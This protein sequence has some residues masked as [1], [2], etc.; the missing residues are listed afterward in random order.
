ML[1]KVSEQLRKHTFTC[2]IILSVFLVLTVI[3]GISLGTSKIPF[4]TV[5]KIILHNLFGL[6]DLEGIKKSTISI[7]WSIRVPRAL[8]GLAVG[9]SLTLSG[10][11]MQAFTKNPL[12]EPYVLGI[13]SGASTGAVI[14][15]L[16]GIHL[17]SGKMLSVSA[18]AF[19]GSIFSIILVYSLA[20][21]AGEI[22]PIRLVLVGV[23]VSAIL[24]AVTNY[25]VYTAPA[26]ASVRQATFWMLGGLSGA[27]GMDIPIP[28]ITLIISTIIMM[29]LAMPLNAMMMGDSSA[30]TLGVNI[31]LIRK[32]LIIDSALLTSTSVAVSGCIGFIG[33]VVPHIVRS[34]VGS[35][36][37]KVIPISLLGGSIMMIWADIAARMI[38]P[39]IELPVGI[40]T[41]MFGGP[42]FLWMIKARKYSFGQ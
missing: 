12:A 8:L 39:P 30:I 41:A 26:E 28:L 17:P 33:L 25:L 18:G 38:M 4:S 23:A 1:K 32:I 37:R 5:W 31:N 13:S 2:C 3:T 29:I 9:G 11:S 15:M 40:I 36:H 27:E 35:D 34:L 7:V 24:R 6:F 42:V 20:R 22:A 19:I 14:A 21:T 16:V 10:I